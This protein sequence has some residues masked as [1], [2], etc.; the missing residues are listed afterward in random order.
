MVSSS[1]P[2]LKIA[3]WSVFDLGARYVFESGWNEKPITLRFNVDNVFDK[4]Y[5]SASNFRYVQLGAPRT[6]WLSATVDF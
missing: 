2:N 6:F 1:N 5:W 3:A 4:D